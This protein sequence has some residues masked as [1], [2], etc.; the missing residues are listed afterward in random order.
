MGPRQRTA[1]EL[2]LTAFSVENDDDEELSLEALNIDELVK[3]HGQGSQ[4]TSHV[5]SIL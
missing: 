2:A 5:C 1:S 4:S 3:L